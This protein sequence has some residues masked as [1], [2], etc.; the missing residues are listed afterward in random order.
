[1]LGAARLDAAAPAPAGLRP[2]AFLPRARAFELLGW[3]FLLSRERVGAG[4]REEAGPAAA[5]D[6]A[7]AAAKAGAD[8]AATLALAEPRLFP[9]LLEVNAGPALEGA[10]WP[11]LCRSVVGD[12]LELIC[13]VLADG[14][15]P[16]ERVGGFVRVF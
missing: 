9:V 4:A 8:R 15:P 13:G 10:A 1:M 7:A 14:A 16:P 2:A 11:A 3:D 6:R 12:A 5:P